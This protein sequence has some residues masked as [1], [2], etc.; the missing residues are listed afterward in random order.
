MVIADWIMG[1]SMADFARRRFEAPVVD[2]G[3]AARRLD[4]LRAAIARYVEAGKAGLH[5][6]TDPI[7]SLSLSIHGLLDRRFFTRAARQLEQLLRHTPSTLTLRIEALREAER[8]HLERLLRRLRRY[9]DRISIIVDEQIRPAV[10]I[11]SS[12]FHL[13]LTAR[14]A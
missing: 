10:A 6:T 8:Q 14:A 3:S 11:D 9:G 12:V 4:S 5:V 13:V 1:L 2:A 7:P